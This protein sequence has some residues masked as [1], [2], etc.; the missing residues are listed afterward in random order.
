[1]GEEG[2][3]E[4][5]D[6][7]FRTVVKKTKPSFLEEK[8]EKREERLAPASSGNFSTP[9]PLH[10][11]SRI[12]FHSKKAEDNNNKSTPPLSQLRLS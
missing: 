6:S 5:R 2:R 1:L 7:T 11:C 12:I 3:K 8:R 4:T 10:K 9:A